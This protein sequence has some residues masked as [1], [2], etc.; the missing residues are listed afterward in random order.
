M[1]RSASSRWKRRRQSPTR[2][3]HSPGLPFS[4][5]TSPS[6]R[7]LVAAASRSRSTRDRRRNVLA[8]AGR[9]V[10][11]HGRSLRCRVP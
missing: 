6:G 5:R 11:R 10:M 1:T 9:A 7:A 2:N 8:T 4:G 3:R